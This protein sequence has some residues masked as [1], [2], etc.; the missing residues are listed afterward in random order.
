[1]SK[2][3]AITDFSVKHY[4]AWNKSEWACV[5]L[6]DKKNEKSFSAKISISQK[7]LVSL[8]DFKFS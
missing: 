4:Q 1:M 2:I 3:I 5:I 6:S 8:H 7:N